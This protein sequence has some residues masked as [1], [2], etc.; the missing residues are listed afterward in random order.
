VDPAPPP[1][2]PVPA[3]LP[4][5]HAVRLITM[6]IASNVAKIRFFM[7]YLPLRK[8]KVSILHYSHIILETSKIYVAENDGCFRPACQENIVTGRSLTRS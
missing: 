3:A 5:P 6:P 8:I 1:A 4:P 7:F 2:A